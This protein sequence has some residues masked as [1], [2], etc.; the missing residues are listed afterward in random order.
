MV[1]FRCLQATLQNK[2]TPTYLH[3]LGRQIAD[4]RGRLNEITTHEQFQV[5]FEISEHLI[6]FTENC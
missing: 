5:T 6:E 2:E 1:N 4:F 3:F